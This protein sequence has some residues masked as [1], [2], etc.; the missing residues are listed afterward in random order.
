[1]PARTE[2]KD[3]E[4]NILKNSAGQEIGF[5]HGKNRRIITY[6]DVPSH[7]VDALIAQEDKRFRSHGAVDFRSMARVAWRALTRGKLEGGGTLSMQLARN[8]FALK[9]QNEGLV[10]GI[11][12]KILETFIAVRI[13]SDFKK[14]EILEHYMNRI[15]WGGSLR[16]VEVAAHA[17]FNKSAKELTL[18]QSALLV[19]IIRA[20]NKFSPFRHLE[21]AKLQRDWVL[22]KMVE[23]NAIT[24]DEADL[25]RQQPLKVSSPNNLREG[26]YALDAIRR[27]L[28]RILEE[29]NI[30]DGGLII[31]TT[32]DPN[33]QELAERSM[34]KRLNQVEQ[35]RS[36]PH[37]KRSQWNGRGTPNYL[38]GAAVVIDNETGGVLA[39]VGGRNANESQFNRALQS[40]RQIGSLFK[41][42]MFL[43]AFDQ[44]VKPY[45]TISDAPIRPGELRGANPNWNPANSDGKYYLEIPVRKSLVESRNTSAIRVAAKAGMENIVAVAR[46]SGFNINNIP[47]VP[48]S[49]LG[50]WG[51]SA[52]AVASAYTI[53]PNGGTRFRPFY[54]QTIKDR[55]GEVLWRNGPIAYQAADQKSAWEV[56]RILEDVNKKGTGRAI[57]STYGF[58]AP[59]GGKTGTTNG[60]TDGWYTGYTSALT[61]AVWVGMD[62]GKTILKGSSGA[63]LALPIWV[64]IMKGSDRLPNIKNG[65]I[66]PARDLVVEPVDD[67]VPRAIPVNDDEIPLATPAR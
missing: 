11:H 49:F 19:G 26:S 67:E 34:E 31:E 52:E 5:L 58:R 15:F 14:N 56:S 35:R 55:S 1:M 13:E 64:D 43:S 32:I 60:P 59:S 30:L 22:E 36:F 54:I 53:F 33:I 38:Q 25:A 63:S 23:N 8:S 66:A 21:R 9:K 44:G 57:R 42:F 2:I 51:A 61:C 40:E 62:D 28:K 46:S 37:Q 27:D 7:F 24:Q 4:G 39:I 65:P 6:A 12:R 3:R 29:E 10:R 47:L 20:P 45:D 16:G 41:P 17:Y 50:S 48:S 18:E